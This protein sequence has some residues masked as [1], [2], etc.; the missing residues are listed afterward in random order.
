MGTHR[1]TDVKHRPG[2]HS[3]T[4]LLVKLN[5]LEIRGIAHAE[6]QVADWSA[7]GDMVVKED[8]MLA[9]FLQEFLEQNTN[10]VRNM[11]ITEAGSG[12][13]AQETSRSTQGSLG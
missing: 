1:G 2:T 13:Q 7:E 8:W 6:E 10:T 4:Q 9:R 5:C 3:N 12:S 11:R